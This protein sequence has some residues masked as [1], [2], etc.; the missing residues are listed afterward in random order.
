MSGCLS[1]VTNFSTRH[2]Y[3]SPSSQN[4]L[5]NLIHTERIKAYILASFAA[6]SASFASF[7]AFTMRGR[8]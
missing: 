5:K 3:A 8:L 2:G 1:S 7:A 4:P 6:S